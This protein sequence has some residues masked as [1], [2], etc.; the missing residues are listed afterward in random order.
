MERLPKLRG[1][2]SK[3]PKVETLYTGELDA[4]AGKTVDNT[5]LA[6]AGRIPNAFSIVK[7]VVKG[8]VTKKV[9]VK[10]QKASEGAIEA[11]QKAGGSFEKTGKAARPAS[12]RVTSRA[13]NKK[14]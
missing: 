7:L 10:L 13:A 5:L 12:T 3:R 2:T 1:F 8:E 14:A 9:T 6:T 11:V 4:F